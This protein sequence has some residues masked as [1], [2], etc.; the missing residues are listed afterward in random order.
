[1]LKHLALHKKNGTQPQVEDAGHATMTR[2]CLA[3]R[4][5]MAAKPLYDNHGPFC[6]AARKVETHS[7][8]IL[9]HTVERLVNID[10]EVLAK[11]VGNVRI[12][13][14]ELATTAIHAQMK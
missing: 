14:A 1:M 11:A 6:V 2:S 4:T 10:Y 5:A 3:C 13:F 7:S 12:R 8:R 9:H